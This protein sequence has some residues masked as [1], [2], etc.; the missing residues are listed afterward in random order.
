MRYMAKISE[1]GPQI[2]GGC[3]GQIRNIT[4]NDVRAQADFIA[5][6][7]QIAA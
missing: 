5:E 7:F 4:G 6:L 3:Y 2:G 1:A